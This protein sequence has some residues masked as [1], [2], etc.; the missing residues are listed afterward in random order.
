ME[1]GLEEG[2]AILKLQR[3]TVGANVEGHAFECRMTLGLDRQVPDELVALLDAVFD[4]EAV[5]DGVVG[6][7]VLDQQVVGPVHRHAAAVG[8]V[9]GGILDVLPLPI[10]VDVPVDRVAR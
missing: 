7:V 1:A 9:D 10:A 4:E 3:L 5:A 8:V 6:H 2:R